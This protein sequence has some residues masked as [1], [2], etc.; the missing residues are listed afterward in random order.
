MLTFFT[1]A[2]SQVQNLARYLLL[3]CIALPVNTILASI[4]PVSPVSA[5]QS[6]QASPILL[7]EVYYNTPGVDLE[8]EWVELAN[9]GPVS[10][11]LSD[12]K[13]GDEEQ[14]RG[15]EGM[16]RFPAQTTIAPAQIIVVA[17]SAVGFRALYGR[18]PDFEII[19]SDSQVPDMRRYA[20]WSTGDFALAN[21]GDELL[22]LDKQNRLV[23]SINYGD[24]TTYFT[25]A[26]STVY[27]GQSIE[28]V[29]ASC[30]TDSAADWQ[31]SRFPSP[32]LLNSEGECVPT[33]EVLAI[34]ES[35][36]P[37]GQIQGAGDISPFVN[38]QV[39][40]RGLVT[41][42]LEDRNSAGITFYTLFV[43]DV[44]GHED[45]DPATSDG[46]A[47]FLG[48]SSP[49]FKTGDIL[50]ISGL[51]TEFYGL[52]EIDD[53]NLQIKSE[54]RGHPLPEAVL[55]E[56]PAEIGSRKQYLESHESMLIA[57]P[58]SALVVGPTH[59]GCGLA[60]VDSQVDRK[61]NPRQTAQDA[62][63]QPTLVLYKSDVDCRD[64]PDVKTGDHISAVSGP[65]TYH[66]DH[67][68]IVLQ[69]STVLQVSAAPWPVLPPPFQPSPDQYTVATFNLN[70][71]FDGTKDM[72][73]SAEPV[74]AAA[75]LA[76]K[77]AKLV[78]ALAATLGCPTIVA[79][80]EVENQSLLRALVESTA[81][82][83]GFTYDISHR[84]SSDSR[85]LDLALLTD[86]RR[87]DVLSV[88]SRQACTTID[89][90]IQDPAAACSPPENP[91]FGRPPLQIDLQIAG[92]P[93]S[94]YVNH[95]KSK[96]EGEGETAAR[97]L[98]QAQHIAQL[99]D[100]Q[101]TSDPQA[102][103]IVLGDFND[104]ERS[105]AVLQM[106][107][108][109]NLVN[110]LVRVPPEDRYS[111]IFDGIPQL[112]DG[113]LLSNALLP[114]VSDVMII[115]ANADYPIGLAADTTLPGLAYR[116]TDHDLP[117]LLL[118]SPADEGPI[119]ID[120]TPQPQPTQTATSSP[121]ATIT[122]PA[123]P[124]QPPITTTKLWPI[125]LLIPPA[126]TLLLLYLWKRSKA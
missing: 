118:N 46:V 2:Y 21:D 115:H 72:P 60:V 71:Y 84:D 55:L 117:L 95:F 97:R 14:S 49:S 30:D 17:Q 80:Q 11:D 104:F 96:R 10:I 64:L 112:I 22:L 79:L 101:L 59:A 119:E 66:F 82:I 29:P 54:S 16:L 116:S 106:T 33:V 5:Q 41:G 62:I 113:I 23:D 126:V 93:V 108:S 43:Q 34:D 110:A 45:G 70:N 98:Q 44:P 6:G 26:I 102:R 107:G 90:G 35:L 42:T 28:R 3:L 8:Q 1:I 77:E 86:P 111:Y 122:P 81:V 61:P 19:D 15:K 89:T 57:I 58:D 121:T 24:K 50:H 56:L 114:L 87:V 74:V 63:K 51:V 53:Q 52:T 9:F 47:I 88:A 75:D 32:G 40:F 25:P 65:L 4:T 67:Y 37:I 13:T 83:C 94:V 20:L 123:P 92:M 7:T 109:A 38:Q 103:I 105:P 31:P 27:T 78:H 36:L 73:S 85:G 99:V 91:L 69:D 12:Y 124:S 100:T 125:L 68:K 18:N 39:E 120:P 76:R 48:R